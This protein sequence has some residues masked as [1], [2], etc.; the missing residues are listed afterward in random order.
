MKST[1]SVKSLQEEINA[2]EETKERFFRGKDQ[3][4]A[5]MEIAR[6]EK[7]KAILQEINRL[8]KE[9]K[10]SDE[11]T[12]ITS[13]WKGYEYIERAIR[14]AEEAGVSVIIHGVKDTPA[15]HLS[16]PLKREKKSYPL[17]TSLCPDGRKLLAFAEEKLSLTEEDKKHVLSLSVAIATLSRHSKIELE[18][19]AEAIQYESYKNEYV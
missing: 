6:L 1:V 11:R 3:F 9:L 16:L 14:I 19:L 15:I 2:W 13:N 5:S 12:P 18:D 8:K 17:D 7:E 10:T 4:I